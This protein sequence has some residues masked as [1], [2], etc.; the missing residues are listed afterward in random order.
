MAAGIDIRHRKTCPGPRADGRC[1]QPAYRA[2]VWI[3]AENRRVRRTFPTLAAAKRWRQDAIVA[4]RAGALAE[5]NTV[6]LEHAA[7]E[8]LDG[9]RSGAIHNRSGDPYKPSAI[10]SYEQNLRIRVLPELGQRRLH[11]IRRADLQ[12]LVQQLHGDGA[13][14]STITTTITPLRAIYAH[15][16]SLDEVQHNPTHGLKLPAV[17]GRRDRIASVSEADL[18]LAALD[19]RDRPLFATAM[20]AGLRRGELTG[21]RWEDLDLASGYIHVRRGWDAREGE[22]TPKSREGRRRVPVPA[23]LRDHLLEHR[24]RHAGDTGYVF[25]TPGAVRISIDRAKDRW[26]ACRLTPI[27]LH[28][29][30]HTYASLMIAAGVN[31]KALSTYMGHANI[32]IT[33]DRYGHLM[34]GNEEQAAGMLDAYLDKARAATV[35]QTVPTA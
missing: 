20:Y 19:D 1:C 24:V 26:T 7:N 33:L 13:N 28:E 21:L 27:T 4:A 8:W 25:S 18:L 15:A 31:A 17:R 22:I 30:R 29:C 14:A 3:A 6:T 2:S 5:P 23:A 9:A 12:R 10:R 16:V 11:E 32:A 35:P 34:P